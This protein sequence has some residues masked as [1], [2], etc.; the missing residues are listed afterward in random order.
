MKKSTILIT[1]VFM[2]QWAMAQTEF[3][4]TY[5]PDALW[6]KYYGAQ[7]TADVWVND[8]VYCFKRNA[9]TGIMDPSYR[10]YNREF[11]P[12]GNLLTA[13]TQLWIDPDYVNS[14]RNEFELDE[15]GILERQ[16]T[17][18]W[19][20]NTMGW[21][22]KER[23]S[24]DYANNRQFSNL[25]K[26][27]FDRNTQT[28][29]NDFQ[30]IY[31]YS[32]YNRPDEFLNQKW[33]DNNWKNDFRVLYTYNTNGLETTSNYQTWDTLANDW[34]N[35]N[36]TFS[37]YDNNVT[38]TQT[39]RETYVNGNDTWRKSTR[40][41]YTYNANNFLESTF[42]ESWNPSDSTWEASGD[43]L[44]YYDND[45]R[46]LELVS[47]F[48]NG[49]SMVNFFRQIREYD[50]EG[51]LTLV[52]SDLFTNGAWV[53]DN[54]C[55]YYYS[56][57]T[58]LNNKEPLESLCHFTN[59]ITTGQLIQCPQWDALQPERWLVTDLSG[60]VILNQKYNGT[61]SINRSLP[62]GIYLLSLVKQ[63]GIIGTTKLKIQP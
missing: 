28:W 35:V 6:E 37:S 57:R 61:I 12:T 19:D 51:N 44:Q 49:V 34:N 27:V 36:R 11:T 14:S 63:G 58:F 13:E 42:N 55:D 9:G 3:I 1:A 60:K 23:S 8:S 15:E 56:L 25:L 26:E 20:N 7:I 24:F 59:P 10:T 22:Y 39:T 5:H 41:T 4:E 29:T 50:A 53:T 46:L 43:Q 16:T 62:E 52:K 47:R 45:G 38:L 18:E 30:N 2:C 17:L 54:Y 48:W 21:Y 33:K 40:S 31:T 32:N